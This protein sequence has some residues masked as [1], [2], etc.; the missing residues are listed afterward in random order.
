[1]NYIS[2]FWSICEQLCL[3]IR[4][5]TPYKRL[6]GCLADAAAASGKL[7]CGA[8]RGVVVTTEVRSPAGTV[9]VS[10]SGLHRPEAG[11]AGTTAAQTA[12]SDLSGGNSNILSGLV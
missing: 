4:M 5:D 11:P 2:K 6:A 12:Y 3:C 7:V 1:M 8:G 9:A 10:S